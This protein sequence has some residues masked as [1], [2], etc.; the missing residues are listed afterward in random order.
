M[1]KLVFENF[2]DKLVRKGFS[3]LFLFLFKTFFLMA[4]TYGLYN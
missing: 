1:L 3:F 2:Q 4:P